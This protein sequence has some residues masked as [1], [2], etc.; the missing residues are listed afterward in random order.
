MPLKTNHLW[1]NTN[2]QAWDMLSWK[3]ISSNDRFKQ[4][5][6]VC[7][8]I[9]YFKLCMF[10]LYVNA[11]LI[12]AD[13]FQSSAYY[14]PLRILG[15]KN[16]VSKNQVYPFWIGWKFWTSELNE[17][18]MNDYRVLRENNFECLIVHL[19]VSNF[20]DADQQHY[21]NEYMELI[22]WSRDCWHLFLVQ[23]LVL[24]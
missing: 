4:R 18:S 11:I 15:E 21:E 8:E 24:K 7:Q 10:F 1:Q 23:T 2:T 5:F 12:V 14:Y 17:C 22:T 16:W 3:K 9:L 13:L 19:T 6:E 20:R